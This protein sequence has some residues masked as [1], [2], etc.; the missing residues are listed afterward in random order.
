LFYKIEISIETITV[1]G[2]FSGSAWNFLR[3]I[4]L[5]GGQDLAIYGNN[6]RNNGRMKREIVVG[7]RTKTEAREVYTIDLSAGG[8]RVG[9]ALLRLPLGEQVELT[10]PK[11]EEKIPFS[12]QVARED[13]MYHLNRIGRD[14]M[15][16]FIRIPDASF[17]EFMSSNYN[18]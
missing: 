11:G 12:G 3:K 8:I 17:S 13:G 1:D 10:M 4:P 5:G 15:A 2:I 6:K 9:G 7:I 16:F 18:V 14:V